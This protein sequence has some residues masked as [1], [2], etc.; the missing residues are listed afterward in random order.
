MLCQKD[1]LNRLKGKRACH[2]LI[3]LL[4]GFVASPATLLLLVPLLAGPHFGVQLFGLQG[5]KIA[6]KHLF[7]KINRARNLF[8]Y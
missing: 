2:T 7:A 6:L 1:H 4:D 3:L 8:L 5:P